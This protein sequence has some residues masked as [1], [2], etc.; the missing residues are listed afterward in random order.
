M[1]LDLEKLSKEQKDNA[2]LIGSKAEKAGIDPDL[3]LALAW[4]ENRFNSKGLSPKGAVGIMQIMPA[5]AKSYG[6]TKEDLDDKYH[7][8]DLG[9]T[10]LK[11]HLTKYDNNPRASLVAYNAGPKV[12]DRYLKNKEVPTS[13]PEETKNYLESIDTIYSLAGGTLVSTEE[14]TSFFD[15]TEPLPAHLKEDPKRV[16]ESAF[17]RNLRVAKEAIQENPEATGALV[18]TAEGYQQ[19][20]LNK[21]FADQ[22][23]ANATREATSM[24]TESS[25]DKWSRKVVGSQ[26]PGGASVTEAASNYQT[27]KKLPPNLALT[28]EGIVLDTLT[29]DRLAAEDRAMAKQLEAERIA[30]SKQFIPRAKN[31][32]QGVGKF[33]KFPGVN[34]LGGL[35]A[36][37]NINQAIERGKEGDYIGAGISGVEA[38]LNAMASLPTVANPYLLGAKGIGTVGSLGMIPIDILYNKYKKSKSKKPVVEV[39][40]PEIIQEP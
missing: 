14:T 10:I 29:K 5:T 32:L 19:Y 6:Y 2:F 13:L 22:V 39:G 3:A 23:K 7:N 20:R 4:Q 30:K 38:G 12:A 24:P 25:G 11:D 9:L 21:E 40:Q 18:G 15:P 33:T 34:V 37:Y 1:A 35:G 31:V 36:G 17:D 26:G 27:A 28:R 16:S 8:I